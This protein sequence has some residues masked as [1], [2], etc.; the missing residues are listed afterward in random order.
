MKLSIV[1][2]VFTPD[3]IT[4]GGVVIEKG[5]ITRVGGNVSPSDA[6]KL[7][8]EEIVLPG[9]IDMHVHMR[10]FEQSKKEDFLSGTMAAAMGGFT[11]VVDMPNTKPPVNS[12][13]TLLKRDATAGSKALVDYGIY[14]GIPHSAADLGEKVRELAT[15][16][17]LFMQKEFYSELRPEVLR[18]LKYAAENNKTVVVHA[19][20]PKFYADEGMGPAGTPDAEASAVAEISSIAERIGFR[21]HITHLSSYLGAREL[22]LWKKKIK[23][24]ADTCPCYLLLTRED[25]ERI[26]AVAKV[27]PPIKS[28][29]DREALLGALKAG[30]I[31]AV[32][33]DHAPHLPEE[34]KDPR[35]ASPGFPG[36][37]TTLPLMLTLVNRG[38]IELE[39]LVRACAEAPARI[40]GLK[41]LGSIEEGKIGNL[42][43][44]DMSKRWRIDPKA[45]VSRGKYSPF[46]GFEVI[47]APAATVVRGKIVMDHGTITGEQGWGRNVATFG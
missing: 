6:M 11:A 7:R 13:P 34:K 47:G 37:E 25:V 29:E 4:D 24:T 10:D 16:F 9:L 42:T 19:E 2:K 12:I 38:V 1:G 41:M 23:I 5:M 45:F 22:A 44:V 46:E 32:S 17:K 36:L 33:S 31:D 27:H 30:Q 35:S 43:V 21:L 20:N 28:R 39:D 14:Y 8:D 40:L 26:G 15:G 3:G 18:T